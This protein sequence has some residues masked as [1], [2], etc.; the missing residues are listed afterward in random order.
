MTRLQN[1]RKLCLKLMKIMCFACVLLKFMFSFSLTFIF[2]CLFFNLTFNVARRT[3]LNH[4]TDVFQAREQIPNLK[5]S[6]CLFPRY[7]LSL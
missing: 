2:L 4:K 3:P 1:D 7:A 6:E 5:E